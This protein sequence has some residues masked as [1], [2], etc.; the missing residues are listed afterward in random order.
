MVLGVIILDIFAD[1]LMN[2]VKSI[3]DLFG[4]TVRRCLG[5]LDTTQPLVGTRL[6]QFGIV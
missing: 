3:L 6:D 5:N 1:V 4:R 2:G